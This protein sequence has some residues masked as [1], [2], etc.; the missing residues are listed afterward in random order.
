MRPRFAALIAALALALPLAAAEPQPRS[1]PEATDIPVEEWTAMAMGRTLTYRIDGA[2]WALEHYYPGT[3]RVT[4]QLYD[5]TCMQGTWDY[6]A[7]IYCFHWEGEGT[8][9]FRHAR[10][11]D[12][13]LIIETQ[14]GNDTPGVQMMTAVTNVPLACGPAVVS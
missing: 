3:N 4:L 8:A 5:G 9:C 1:H 14:D 6:S 10:R 11:G 12:E 2:L 13:I 7:P